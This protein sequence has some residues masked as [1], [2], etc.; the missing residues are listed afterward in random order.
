ME[1]I[2]IEPVAS[3]WI[4][5]VIMAVMAAALWIGPTF[6][7][8]NRSQKKTLFWLRF[9]LL[10]LALIALLRPGIVS[11][12]QQKQTA[13]L[14]VLLDYSRSMRLPHLATGPSRWDAMVE[15]IKQNS[16]RFDDLRA[17][18]IDVRFFR[19]GNRLKPLDG[20]LPDFPESPSD[21]ESDLGSALYATVDQVRDQRLL[22]VIMG[23]DGVSN[24][25]D[26]EIELSQAA[27]LLEDTQ[28]P[29]IT[30]PF[31]QPALT[32]QFADIA[33]ENMADQ[34][35]VWVKNDLVV[36]ATVRARGFANQEIPVQLIVIDD[37]GNEE[38]VDTV[39]R[40][41]T[42]QSESVSVE[43]S[44]TPE[45]A[46]QYRL[47]VR[48][49][50]QA[51]EVSPRNNELPAFLTVNEGGLR[52][53]Y[54]YGSLNWEVA[55]LIRS[56]SSYQDI[57]L[58]QLHMDRR[59]EDRWPLDRT[60]L[61]GDSQYDVFILHNVDSTSLYQRGTQENNLRLLAE[62]VQGGK[63]LIMIGGYESFGPGLYHSTPLT[64]VLPIEME[65]S[66]K[67]EFEAPIREDLHIPREL[68]PRVPE[69]QRHFI[70]Q[71]GD[72]DENAAIWAELPPLVGANRF[73]GIKDTAGVLLES[74]DG[75]VLMAAFRVG[76][77]V[78]AFAGDTTYL[79]WTHGFQDTHKRFWRQVIL[80]LA[81]KDSMSGQNVR[82]DLP[83][84]RFQPNASIRFTAEANTQTKQQIIDARFSGNLVDPDGTR[85][86]ITVVS[87]SQ[88]QIDR[89][90]LENPGIYTIEVTAQRNDQE[91]GTAAA[92]F[93][94]FD[95]DKEQANPAANP[96]QL[97]R[98]AERTSDFGGRMI[99]PADLPG[100]LD[101]LSQLAPQM[102]VEVPLKWQLGDTWYD[103]L[104]FVLV[105]VG[106]VSV[107]WWL[108][109][110]WGMV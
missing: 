46:G 17:Q 73:M 40:S 41:F 14:A 7:N 62:A 33:V 63:G 49:E 92:E 35:T 110:K 57:Q 104:L 107:E 26:P 51:G 50:P 98:L 72:P 68:T 11:T 3:W 24:V 27:K 105:F 8:L 97:S 93:V 20:S 54:V 75:E 87:G 59:D 102:Q 52:V 100:V 91:I 10:G 4:I 58:D 67:Q 22:G 80:W 36:T 25:A 101:D 28:T 65:F 43:L 21:G 79:W 6:A 9:A 60:H 56:L 47:L 83:Q 53:L 109:K 66:E 77:R 71:L 31:G 89:K 15:L 13:V 18:N 108:R 81:F 2:T 86:A 76:G 23:S 5:A 74:T 55:Y 95:N 32:E 96:D 12:I 82:I 37:D 78:L 103:A 34:Y 19:F 44:Y 90:L 61:F 16:D 99:E 94:I 30:V 64:H 39:R 48:A 88:S 45:E 38:V 1:R 42:K 106:L 69:G 84:R 85:T 29:L 70:T